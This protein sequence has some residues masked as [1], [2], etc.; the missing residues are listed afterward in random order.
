MTILTPF[1]NRSPISPAVIRSMPLQFQQNSKLERD[2][3]ATFCL[4]LILHVGFLLLSLFRVGGNCCGLWRTP[5]RDSGRFLNSLRTVSESTK[6]FGNSEQTG[7][8]AT[9]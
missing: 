4:I 1:I 7:N 6:V 3:P 9:S 5:S 8:A 2:Y